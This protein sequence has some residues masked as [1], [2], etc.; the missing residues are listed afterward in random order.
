MEYLPLSD[1]SNDALLTIHALEPNEGRESTLVSELK[2][3]TKRYIF[4]IEPDFKSAS[5]KQKMR[6]KQFGYIRNLDM[7]IEKNVLNILERVP[8]KNNSNKLNAAAITVIEK[9]NFGV[10]KSDLIWVDLIYRDRLNPFM[11]GLRTSVGLWYPAVNNSL[12]YGE[13]MLST[14]Y[15]PHAKFDLQN[16]KKRNFRT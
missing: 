9:A 15:R 14:F 8:I 5:A 4:L 16:I 1:N 3:V 6:I 2:R 10:Q 12:C 7:V 11:S 13:R